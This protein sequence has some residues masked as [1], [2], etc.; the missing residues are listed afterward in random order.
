MTLVSFNSN[1]TDVTSALGTTTL[2]EYQSSPPIFS[3]VHVAQCLVLCVAFCESL[4]IVLSVLRF[5]L[6]ITS[7]VS[8]N[9]PICILKFIFFDKIDNYDYT[10]L[11]LAH[12]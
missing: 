4:T 2:P 8:S 6:L 5:A 3:G 9:Y 11:N 1:S 12:S 10:H 7:S